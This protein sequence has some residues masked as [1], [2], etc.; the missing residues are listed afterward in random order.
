MMQKADFLK[1][2]LEDICF[3]L[4]MYEMY[5]KRLPRDKAIKEMCDCYRER[6]YMLL[7]EN[8]KICSENNQE[9][10]EEVYKYYDGIQNQT[11]RQGQ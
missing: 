6:Y 4:R 11:F 2:R 10:P 1:N 7:K 8:I 3:V 9:I 5:G